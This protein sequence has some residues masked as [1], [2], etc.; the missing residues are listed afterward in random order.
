[1]PITS[2][3]K[4]GRA[5]ANSTIA[6]AFHQY[7]FFVFEYPLPTIDQFF[8]GGGSVIE[9]KKKPTHIMRVGFAIAHQRLRPKG[10]CDQISSLGLCVPDYI[11]LAYFPDEAIMSTQYNRDRTAVR[12]IG[13]KRLNNIN[14]QMQ[15]R[16]LDSHL[17]LHILGTKTHPPDNN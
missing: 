9:D 8:L 11:H 7:V 4:T 17:L 2:A 14:R 6:C 15:V 13:Y 16:T 1:M 5:I 10:L 3:R 12:K